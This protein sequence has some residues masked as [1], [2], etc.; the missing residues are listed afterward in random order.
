MGSPSCPGANGL[1]F[2][3]GAAWMQGIPQITRFFFFFFLR[4]P[5]QM[6]TGVVFGKQRCPRII[7]SR[8]T[9]KLL[10]VFARVK[11][12]VAKNVLMTVRMS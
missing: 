2:L 4:L 10:H 8:L 3:E 1:T 11:S 5:G 9:F 6:V 12:A 7:P